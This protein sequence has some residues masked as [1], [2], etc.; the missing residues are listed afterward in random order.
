MRYRIVKKFDGGLVHAVYSLVN[1]RIEDFRLTGDFFFYPEEKL[2]LL[3]K[4]LVGKKI[5]ELKTTIISFYDKHGIES[6][7]VTPWELAQA[8]IHAVPMKDGDEWEDKDE[9]E[10]H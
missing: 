7:G 3:E 6:P 10:E 1:G 2:F 4:E 9:A 5:T 8:I